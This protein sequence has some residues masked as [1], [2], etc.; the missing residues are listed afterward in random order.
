MATI[1]VD[2]A[3]QQFM[4]TLATGSE[5][6]LNELKA[7]LFRE[8]IRLEMQKRDI[9]EMLERVNEDRERLRRE[10]DEINNQIVIERKRLKDEQI[11]FDKKMEILKN[12]FESLEMDRKAFNNARKQFEYEKTLYKSAPKTVRIKNE[13]YVV[14]LFNGV[15]SMLTL[16]KRY[17]D[18]LKIFHPDNMGGDHEMVLSINQVYEELKKNYESSKIV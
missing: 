7:F 15:N 6:E 1:K 17:R 8:N 13:E 9:E 5:E 18:L 14:F 4:K 12:G 3:D 11:F 2:E 10:S 16:K